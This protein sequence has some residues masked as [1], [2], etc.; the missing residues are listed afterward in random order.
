MKQLLNTYK[1]HDKIWLIKENTKDITGYDPGQI[2][3]M[4]NIIKTNGLLCEYV[5]IDERKAVRGINVI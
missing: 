2:K 1:L 3:R 5:K 4:V